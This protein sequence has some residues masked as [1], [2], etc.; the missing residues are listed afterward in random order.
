MKYFILVLTVTF[1]LFAAESQ[2]PSKEEMRK[3]LDSYVRENKEASM[4]IEPLIDRLK[5]IL[6]A[7]N[8]GPALEKKEDK[9][10]E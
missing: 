5:E 6:G 3:R 4:T 1:Q 2:P 9:K 7:G 10:L 8:R